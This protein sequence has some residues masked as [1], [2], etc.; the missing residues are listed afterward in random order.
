MRLTTLYAFCTHAISTRSSALADRVNT[1][2]GDP[3]QVELAFLAEIR[4]RAELLR[5][6]PLGVVFVEQSQVDE[7]DA[8]ELQRAQVVLDP[9]AQL[10]WSLCRQPATGIVAA[11]SDLRH[12]LQLL[13]VRMERLPDHLVDP[14]G[15]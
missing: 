14:V 3:D 11:P 10:G 4:E 6:A 13:R 12:E 5:Q 9:C 2:V 7:I 15:P 8:L 1:G